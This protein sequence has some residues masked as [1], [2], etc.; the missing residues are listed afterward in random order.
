MAFFETFQF[1]FFPCQFFVCN[2]WNYNCYSCQELFYRKF[3]IPFYAFFQAHFMSPFDRCQSQFCLYYVLLLLLVSVL[4][5]SYGQILVGGWIFC[6][7]MRRTWLRFDV[8]LYDSWVLSFCIYKRTRL[9]FVDRTLTSRS[10]LHVK[11]I[12]FWSPLVI[13]FPF[14]KVAFITTC[15][16]GMFFFLARRSQTRVFF[17]RNEALFFP[18]YNMK[19]L[20]SPLQDLR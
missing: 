9:W 8:I 14:C 20:Q 4:S 19:S 6:F 15:L 3:A 17:L 12:P 13:I 1:N 7:F 10:F 2:Q 5:S 11:T 18:F 16:F